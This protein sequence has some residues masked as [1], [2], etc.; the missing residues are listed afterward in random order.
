MPT[1]APYT[2]PFDGTGAAPSNHVTNEVQNITAVNSNEFHIVVPNFAPFFRPVGGIL[3]TVINGTTMTPMSEGVDYLFTHKFVEAT[4]NTGIPVYGSITLLDKNFSG[5]L[6]LD[7]QTVGGEWT[8]NETKIN[9]ILANNL[10]NPRITT[11]EQLGDVPCNFPVIDHL[12]V[13]PEEMI[14]MPELVAAVEA[15]GLA[16]AGMDLTIDYSAIYA[17]VDSKIQDSL[18]PNTSLKAPSVRAVNEALTQLQL[19]VHIGPIA[20]PNPQVKQLWWNNNNGRM[21]IYYDDGDTIQWVETSPGSAGSNIVVSGETP[22]DDPFTDQ[23]WW[24]PSTSEMSIYDGSNWL[25]VNDPGSSSIPDASLSTKGIIQIAS[26]SEILSGDNSILKAVTPYNL[27]NYLTTN[28]PAAA[29]RKIALFQQILPN[30]TPDIVIQN[31]SNG[32]PFR[33]FNTE[34]YNTMPYVGG[35][36]NLAKIGDNYFNIY[37]GTYHIR[38][39]CPATSVNRHQ[40]FLV[41]SSTWDETYAIGTSE[42]AQSGVTTSSIIDTIITFNV[43]RQVCVLHYTPSGGSGGTYGPTST[44]QELYSTFFIE[45][46]D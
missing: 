29:S 12:H 3:F 18:D 28:P 17:Y 43:F 15:I 21:F 22:P 7:Y 10:L 40:I 32:I 38:I 44:Q 46:L 27:R 42:N 25:L 23:L 26:P 6:I 41:K 1:P 13:D 5:L 8:L 45:K 20:P 30:H 35:N 4:I 36:K 39:K 2:Y 9:E 31:P 19:G 37:P 24:K 34:V 11:W 33:Y 16:L 14:G